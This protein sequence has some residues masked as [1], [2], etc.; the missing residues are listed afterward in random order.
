MSRIGV[1]ELFVHLDPLLGTRAWIWVKR[2]S[3]PNVPG[4]EHLDTVIPQVASYGELKAQV[5]LLKQDLDEVLRKAKQHF[6][7]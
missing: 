7:T 2:T 1:F 5:E 6:E 3:A 4:A